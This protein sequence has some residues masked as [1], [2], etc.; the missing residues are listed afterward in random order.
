MLAEDSTQPHPRYLNTVAVAKVRLSGE[1]LMA[2]LLALEASFGRR[3]SGEVLPR[4]LDLDL[5]LLGRERCRRPGLT[6]PHPRM[7][8]RSF[9]REPLEALRPGLLAKAEA[10]FAG[11]K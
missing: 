11:A 3:R 4:T 2:R 5:L 6:L 8:E 1:V 10:W 7:W 9:V